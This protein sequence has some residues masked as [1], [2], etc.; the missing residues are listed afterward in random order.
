MSNIKI[1]II[2][3][4]FFLFPQLARAEDFSKVHGDFF[5]LF[6]SDNSDAKLKYILEKG[7]K[8]KNTSAEYDLDYFSF[9]GELPVPQSR[10]SF[11]RFGFDYG[12]RMY[13]FQG[14][15]NFLGGLDSQD[16]HRIKFSPG[17][18]TFIN[19]N[20]LLTGN[21][22]L[23]LFTNFQKSPDFDQLKYYANVKLVWRLNP[24]SL[25]YLGIERSDNFDDLTVYPLLGIKLLTEKGEF[26]I[27]LDLPKELKLDY[28]ITSKSQ[29]YFLVSILG[30]KYRIAAGDPER[31]FNVFI[32]DKRVGLGANH[33]FTNHIAF[34]FE[35]GL[36][37]ASDFEFETLDDKGYFGEMDT[38]GYLA[39]ALKFAL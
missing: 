1:T 33:W 17:Y 5:K 23:G 7:Q 3:L 16:L 4:F 26:K 8:D 2:F 27:S 36:T 32:Q 30:E 20:L 15:G 19:D 18:G 39:A 14:T 11:F 10:D 34:N 31:E 35:V 9:N 22:D 28:N 38:G 13:D 24:G 37:V 12:L 25:L 6:L 21:F 29:L